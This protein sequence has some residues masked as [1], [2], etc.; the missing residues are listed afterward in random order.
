M[1]RV[2]WMWHREP[3]DG[4][5]RVSFCSRPPFV[6]EQITQATRYDICSN[7]SPVPIEL[8][9]TNYLLSRD[10]VYSPALSF[11]P[12]TAS[13]RDRLS[14]LFIAWTSLE[15]PRIRIRIDPSNH[16]QSVALIILPQSPQQHAFVSQNGCHCDTVCCLVSRCLSFCHLHC[17]LYTSGTIIGFCD[18]TR[19]HCIRPPKFIASGTDLCRH[20]RNVVWD[21][22]ICLCFGSTG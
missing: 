5:T 10:I 3:A 8:Q 19:W 21:R 1:I 9:L 12:Y 18:T 16:H 20:N 2:V 11:I 6:V 14:N 13:V 17:R 7:N 4:S 22:G 15:S